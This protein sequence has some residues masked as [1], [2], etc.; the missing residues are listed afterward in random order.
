MS[1]DPAGILVSTDWL[2]A[3]LDA[4]RI[5]DASW[6]L[7]GSGRDARSEWAAE[8]IPGARFF[9]IDQVAA[10]DSTLPHTAPPADVFLE[11]TQA[12]GIRDG[13]Q[14][15]I[16]DR[17]GIFSAPRAWWLF[18]MSG[19]ETA[20]VLDGGL[21]KWRREGRPLQ[22]GEPGH[23]GGPGA[24]RAEPHQ[25]RPLQ[26]GEPGNLEQT[27]TSP[28]TLRS[29]CR[30]R[31]LRQADEV[32]AASRSGSAQ[33]VD[34]RPEARFHGKEAEPRPGL[35]AGHIPAARNVPY[36]TLLGEDGCLRD[37]QALRQIFSRAGVDLAAPVI[38]SCGSG[39]T[40]AIV[41]LALERLGHREHALYDGSWAEW[42]ASDRPIE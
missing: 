37:R 14:I 36:Q 11:H 21:G 34:A 19:I 29:E 1:D 38:T 15:V 3:R 9:D 24:A 16:Y 35:R 28:P 18:R 23:L 42:G 6:H 4:V 13:D 41:N 27:K 31:W 33:I 10:P 32:A 25:S 22:T 17:D 7:P 5:L 8:R 26:T 30:A 40:A 20:A 39:V 2:A 12:L